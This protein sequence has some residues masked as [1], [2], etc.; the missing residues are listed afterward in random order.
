M[1]VDILCTCDSLVINIWSLWNYWNLKNRFFSK[2]EISEINFSSTEGVK[3]IKNIL[4]LQKYEFIQ[5]ELKK[6]VSLPNIKNLVEW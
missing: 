3:S 1:Q 5:N 6:I 4:I 2:I